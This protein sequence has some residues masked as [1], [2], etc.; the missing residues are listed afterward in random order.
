MILTVVQFTE[1]P[2]CVRYNTIGCTEINKIE[3]LTSALL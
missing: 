2:A 1:F 3:L